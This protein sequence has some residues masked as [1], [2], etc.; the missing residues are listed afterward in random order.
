MM[1]D[2]ERRELPMSD[3]TEVR[4]VLR[5]LCFCGC[6]VTVGETDQ[7]PVLL[8]ATPACDRFLETPIDQFLHDVRVHWETHACPN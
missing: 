7:G 1:L 3:E 8:H 5:V 6:W 2:V 4:P